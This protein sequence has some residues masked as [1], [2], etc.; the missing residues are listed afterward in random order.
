MPLKLVSGEARSL[1]PI[2]GATVFAIIFPERPDCEAT[3]VPLTNTFISL[4][5]YVPTTWCHAF[6]DI[7]EV[8]DVIL[9]SLVLSIYKPISSLSP[10]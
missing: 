3:S 9:L 4:P 2:V 1:P 10:M 5:S 7:G 6:V 8:V